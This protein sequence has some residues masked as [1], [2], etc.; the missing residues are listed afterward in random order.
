MTAA[1]TPRKVAAELLPSTLMGDA[2]TLRQNLPHRFL[3]IVADLEQ[4]ANELSAVRGQLEESAKTALRYMAQAADET[5]LR[6]RAESA[7][8]AAK[9]DLAYER[10]RIKQAN[11]WQPIETAPKDGTDVIVM[12]MHI[13]TQVVHNAFFSS[14]QEN[15]DAEDI[16]WWSYEHFE[17]RRIKL[18]DWMAPT[19]WMP[20][21][22]PPAKEEK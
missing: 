11:A 14:E 9:A 8:A 15:W 20:L 16:G 3:D 4:A 2:E 1:Q 19:H 13:D 18:D 10:D 12:Y 22:Q 7:L 21:P 6:E 5:R 17:V